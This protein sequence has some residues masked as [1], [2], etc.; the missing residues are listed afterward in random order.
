LLPSTPIEAAA[1][2]PDTSESRK[3]GDRTVY[4]HYIKSMGWLLARSSFFAA[5]WGFLINFA[6]ISE[7]LTPQDRILKA[8]RYAYDRLTYWTN[9]SSLDQ[10]VHS[11]AYYAGIYALFQVSAVISLLLLGIALFIASVKRAGTRLHHDALRRTLM[12]APL[13]FFAK[14]DTGVVTN[15]F[16]QDLNL[17]DTELPDATL[18]TLIAVSLYCTIAG[19]FPG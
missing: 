15:L 7:P 13:A 19:G 3:V 10:P 4:K 9:D 14:M 2:A 18:N 5:L 17:I 8:H 6:T 1:S 16:S 12:R 11:Y